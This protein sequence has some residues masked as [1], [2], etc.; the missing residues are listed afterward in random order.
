M[1]TLKRRRRIGL[2]CKQFEIGKTR[3][4]RPVCIQKR[5]GFVGG[6][7]GYVEVEEN[8]KDCG[9]LILREELLKVTESSNGD[10]TAFLEKKAQLGSDHG[11]DPIWMPDF[12]FDFQK[13]LVE[14]ALRKG[15]GAMFADCG[16]GKTPVS[17]VWC[18]NIIRKENK[19]ILILTPLAVAQQFVREGEKFGIEVHYARDGIVRKGIN[20]VNYQRLHY[21]DPSD[22]IGL[23]C[24]ESGVLKHHD[25]K[26][27]KA[28]TDFCMKI[29]Y[30]LLG[31]ATPAPNDFMELG[32]SAEVLGVMGYAQML[33]MFFIND[34]DTT[35]QWRLK[36]HAKKR[37][38]Q[39]VSTW[40][41]AVRKPSDLGFDDDGFILS[42]LN[43]EQHTVE[44][45]KPESG[46]L[47]RFAAKTL[48]EQR[49]E[50]RKTLRE[51]CEK[52]AE[53]CPKDRSF[54]VWCQL[55]DEGNLLEEL[56]P[57]AVQVKGSDDNDQ[58]EERLNGFAKGDI[59]VLVT[60]PKIGGWG[61]NLQCCSDVAYFPSH[62]W[63]S[64]YQA[65]RRC[66]RFGQKREVNVHVVSSESE[67]LV[68][69][70]MTRKERQ[71]SELYDGIIREMEDFQLGRTDKKQEAMEELEV[72]A[73]LTSV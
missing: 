19:P 48:N 37:F 61:L 44:A 43:I 20:V 31:T 8:E 60:K 39:W 66:W 11:F 65:V 69:S 34:G 47:F 4:F 45:S 35:S 53:L 68:V 22:F 7:S 24:D 21:F 2:K 14:W 12:L 46:Q 38:W 33:G 5:L 30:R 62:S 70:N 32:N 36:G 56:L 10:Y 52:V 26:T 6:P 72:P 54:I 29:P 64:W 55:N 42:P 63:E 23:V 3:Y 73:W 41:R 40:A 57:D 13:H 15:R 18:E 59:R 25:T 49:R 17:L 1:S 51:R 16:L 28:V 67:S 9:P 27:R 50:R 71:S 58:K